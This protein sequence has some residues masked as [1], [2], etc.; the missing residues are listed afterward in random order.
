MGPAVIQMANAADL[1]IGRRS[2]SVV[3]QTVGRCACSLAARFCG[4]VACLRDWGLT[5]PTEDHVATHDL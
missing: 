5:M 2:L 4:F 1:E 3:P